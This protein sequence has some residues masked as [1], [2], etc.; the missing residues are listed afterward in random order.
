[1]NYTA[2]NYSASR[3]NLYIDSINM[4]NDKMVV[5]DLGDGNFALPLQRLGSLD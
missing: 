5:D 3:Q 4:C 2:N 1:M